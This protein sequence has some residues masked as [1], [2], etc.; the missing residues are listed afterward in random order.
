VKQESSGRGLHNAQNSVS[1]SP[2]LQLLVVTSLLDQ[3]KNLIRSAPRS[4]NHSSNTTPH[5]TPL[6]SPPP[7]PPAQAIACL[8][9][10]PPHS[11]P[12]TTPSHLPHTKPTDQHTWFV[13][14]A[15]ARGKALGL[16]ADIVGCKRTE[17][18]RGS[19]DVVFVLGDLTSDPW[20]RD[21][22]DRVRLR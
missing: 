9:S 4:P 18:G 3:V 10:T 19:G 2:L 1:D 12:N 15:L 6:T 16:G 8:G 13:N 7:I 21:G 22:R 20:S 14:C 5:N 11:I 17:S